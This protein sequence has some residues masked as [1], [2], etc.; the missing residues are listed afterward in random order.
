MSHPST[1]SVTS[2]K[3]TKPTRSRAT[4]PAAKPARSRASNH[5]RLML[6]VLNEA[7]QTYATGLTSH[8]VARRSDAYQV[9]LWTASDSTDWPFSFCNVCA[10]LGVDPDY[11]RARMR[12]LRLTLFSSDGPAH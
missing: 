8:V 12:R 6:A 7:L 2:A 5:R 3:A 9:E 4:S 10:V 11:I 1:E